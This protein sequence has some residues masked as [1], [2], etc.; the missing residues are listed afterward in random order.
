MPVS[1]TIEIVEN[2]L[3]KAGSLGECYPSG[4]AG[5]GRFRCELLQRILVRSRKSCDY[6]YLD[7]VMKLTL[8][9]HR[10]TFP[11]SHPMFDKRIQSTRN[12]A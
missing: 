7:Y 2:L 12:A 1:L 10:W 9:T 11:A 8:L 6:D 3:T 5:C 4:G